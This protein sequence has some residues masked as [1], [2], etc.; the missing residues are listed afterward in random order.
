M[1]DKL[2]GSRKV[3]KDAS[4]EEG[5]KKPLPKIDS[6][7]QPFYDAAQKHELRLPKCNAC[8]N[9]FYPPSIFCPACLSE[10]LGWPLLSG[11]GKVWSFIFMYQRYFPA[12]ADEIPYNIAFVQIDEGPLLCT[13]LVGIANEDIKC[14]MPVEVFFDDATPEVTLVKFRPV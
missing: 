5:Y 11:K 9:I 4:A 3:Y 6:I 8:G 10:D 12:F 7:N 1:T 14:D 13:N 2:D